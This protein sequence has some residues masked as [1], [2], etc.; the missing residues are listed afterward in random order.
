[1]SVVKQVV[2]PYLPGFSEQDISVTRQHL[3][4]PG[5]KQ[6]RPAV[7]AGTKVNQTLVNER[8]VV[9]VSKQVQI[10]VRSHHRFARL[11]F[12]AKGKVVK[13]VLSR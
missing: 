2:E 8:M 6:D 7:P 12:N 11:T 1:M 4:H 13:M 3:A 10:G 9:T 5:K